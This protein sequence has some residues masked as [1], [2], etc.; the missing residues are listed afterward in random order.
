MQ[1][2][3][4]EMRAELAARV[5]LTIASL[6]PYWPLLTFSVVLVSEDHFTSDIFNGELPVRVLVGQL[7]RSGQLPLWTNQICSGYPLFGGPSDPLGL[8]LFTLLPPAAA[9][10]TLLILI[11]LVAAHGT[12]GLARRF[13]V[14]RSAAVLAGFAFAGSG[15]IASQLKH[16]SIMWTIV[17]LPVGLILIDRILQTTPV[18]AKPPGDGGRGRALL[19]ATLGLLYAHQGLAGFPQAVYICGLVY[20]AFALFRVVSDPRLRSIRASVPLL[21]GIAGA[22]AIG[23]AAG[24]V[25]LLPLFELAG[26]SDRS[27]ALDF[28]WATY[29]NFWPPN[30]LTFFVPY[31]NGD[32]SNHTY[33]G[34]P[35]FWEQYG[36]V[37]AATALLAI[38]GA[39]RERRRPLVVFLIVMTIAAFL[40]ILGPRTPV[41]YV[42]YQLIPGLARLRAPTR[43]LVVVD[44]GLVLLAAVGLTRLRSDLER[45]WQGVSRIPRT[46]VWAICVVTAVDLFYHQ[47]RWNPMVP[48][49]EWFA[50]PR[51]A[52]IVRADTSNP[53]TYTP[54]HRDVHRRVHDLEARGTMNLEPYFRLRDLLQPNL[55]GGYWNVPSG[56]CYVGLAPRW[57]V[58]VW[59]YHYDEHALIQNAAWHGFDNQTLF[60]APT[61]PNLLRTFGVTHVLSRYPGE[62]PRLTLID[63]QP[64]SYVY[65]VEGTA[66]VRVVRAARRMPTDAVAADRLREPTFD[67]DAEILLQDAPD[68]IRPIVNDTG[69]GSSEGTRGRAAITHEDTRQLVIDAVTPEDGFLLVADMYY[70]GWRAEVD[71]VATPIYRANVSVRGIALPKG[72]HTV[73]FTYEP[74]SFFRGL[75][76]T[77]IALGALVLWFGAAAYRA[78]A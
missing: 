6:A 75:W 25:V 10:D 49:H 31:I 11:L 76:I 42:A 58:S 13:G 21:A 78:Y 69:N 52:G 9:L 43:F 17:W 34:P 63:R 16:V 23:A 35:P 1:L 4:H 26:V 67:P 55:G 2:M 15:Y 30:V 33:I 56:D 12:Y 29:T 66:R 8:A 24:A 28:K 61:F 70:P 57:Y 74:S 44:L 27:N 47:P 51:T 72:Q 3:R 20:A 37:G 18:S 45:R 7:I 5:V 59:S 71:G 77:S 73:R 38:Y 36:Y 68:S 39:V 48:A 46:I 19:L 50:P 32:T 60:L 41:Y 54:H 22:L 53:R 14:D 64:D 40:L 65:R 62:D